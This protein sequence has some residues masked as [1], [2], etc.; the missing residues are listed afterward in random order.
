VLVLGVNLGTVLIVV[1][2]RILALASRGA[3][4]GGE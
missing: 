1:G 4:L 3:P 2:P